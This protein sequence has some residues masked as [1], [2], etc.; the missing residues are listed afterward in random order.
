MNT[1]A[2]F[3]S[4]VNDVKFDVNSPLIASL[5]SNPEKKEI[6]TIDKTN[7]EAPKTKAGK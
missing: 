2:V 7:K 1:N 4:S 5:M 6:L 3:K